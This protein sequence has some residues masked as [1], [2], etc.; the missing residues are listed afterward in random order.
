[1]RIE[2]LLFHRADEHDV[3]FDDRAHEGVLPVD[4]RPCLRIADGFPFCPGAGEVNAL[5]D[6][7]YALAVLPEGETCVLLL[8]GFGGELCGEGVALIAEG[9]RLFEGSRGDGL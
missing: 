6:E 5:G 8:V 1:M 3:L 2:G 9:I 7:G 4:A